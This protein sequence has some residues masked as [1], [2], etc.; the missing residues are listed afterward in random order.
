MGNKLKFYG[1]HRKEI[2]NSDQELFEIYD[3]ALY[4]LVTIDLITGKIK[5]VG[6]PVGSYYPATGSHM[7]NNKLV[8]TKSP[9]IVITDEMPRTK[10]Q[11]LLSE[12]CE[13]FEVEIKNNVKPRYFHKILNY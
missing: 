10:A 13:W 3:D 8:K 9:T 4:D 6:V 2:H 7:T 1:Y 5:A 11:R 12:W